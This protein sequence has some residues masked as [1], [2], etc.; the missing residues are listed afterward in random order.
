MVWS[1]KAFAGASIAKQSCDF[2]G[3]GKDI[4]VGSWVHSDKPKNSNGMVT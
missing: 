2:T 4:V 3:D 1:S